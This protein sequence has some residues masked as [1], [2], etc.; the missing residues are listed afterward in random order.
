MLGPPAGKN[1]QLTCQK[2]KRRTIEQARTIAIVA[3][4]AWNLY[5]FRQGLI[6]AFLA[7]GYRVILVA[8]DGPER[9]ALEGAN[10]IFVPLKHLRRRSLNP[11]RDLAL[12][13]E[14]CR[15][16]QKYEISTALHFTIKPVV[17]GSFAARLAG[18]RNVSTLT[19]LGYS[20]I[21]GGVTTLIAR[22]LYRLALRTATKV[23]FHNPDD[24]QLFLDGGLVT[25]A[26]SAVV[27]G[28]GL[29]LEDYPQAPYTEAVPGRFLFVG[30]LLAD[31]G[32]R[33]F[34][35][36]ARLAKVENPRL[37]FHLLG[38]LDPGN[39]AGISESELATWIEEGAVV[40]DGVATDIRPQ[41]RRS[42]VVVLPSYREG[43]PRVLLE[44]AA[45]GRVLVGAD[46]PGVREVVYPKKNGWLA[47]AKDT[48]SLAKAFQ[49]A[50]TT[51]PDELATMA[52]W[53]R[54]LVRAR[55]EEKEVTVAYLEAIGEVYL[56]TF[57]DGG[58]KL[59]K[60]K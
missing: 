34:V 1:W 60:Y 57:L 33:E 53:G 25:A 19:G 23:F 55:F 32:V 58:S 43:C 13:W 38:P 46:V 59:K 11:F 2:H 29:P 52:L 21:K 17:Y 8:P 47:L 9:V 36:A 7:V 35:A 16:Y 18:T 12:M 4:S 14:L 49:A 30:R 39:P 51:Q 6:R 50:A 31:K 10:R 22:I 40:Y 3:N 42:S 41:I 20:F 48:A 56:K 24:R 28:S 44:A 5:N 15:I 45:T 27:N 54:E 26:R 37:S